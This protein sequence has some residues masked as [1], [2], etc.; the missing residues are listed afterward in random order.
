[1]THAIILFGAVIAVAIIYSSLAYLWG[2]ILRKL[3]E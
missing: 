2:L 3:D 1:M